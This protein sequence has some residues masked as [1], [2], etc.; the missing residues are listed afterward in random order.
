[1][2]NSESSGCN[3]NV[4]ALERRDLLIR[5]TWRLAYCSLGA[6]F[7]FGGF[8]GYQ[9]WRKQHLSRQTEQFVA[10]GDY[11]SAVLVARRLL[12][13]D[14]DNLPASRAMAEMAENAGQSDAIKWRERLAHLQPTPANHIALAKTALRFGQPVLAERVLEAVPE[15]SRASVAYH[16]VA[17]ALALAQKD[18]A[19]AETHFASALKI[20][21]QNEQV[22]LNLAIVRLASADS[23][24]ASRARESL[25]ALSHQP[26]VRLEALRALAALALA[27]E[28]HDAAEKWT[29]E[30]QA[31][32][33]TNFSDALLHLQ[34]A[35]G[36]EEAN[37]TLQ[38]VKTKAARA[39]A[40]AAELITWLNRHRQAND[41][42]TWATSLPQEILTAQP[43]P[44]AVAESYSFLQDWPALQSWVEGKNWGAFEA[45]RLAVESHAL[46]RLSPPDRPSLQTETVWRA[47]LKTAQ[48]HPEQLIAIAQLAEGWGYISDAQEAWW[49]VA[50]SND[51]PKL[52]LSA[53]QRLYKSQQDTHGLLRVAKRALELNPGDLVA[54]NN[55]ASLGLLLNGDSTSR[56][57][58]SRL[59]SEHPANRAF[60]ATYAFAL[61]SEGKSSE[62]LKVM[63]SLQ[64]EELRHPAIAAY[65]VVLLVESGNLERARAYLGNAQRA[66]LLPEEERLLNSAAR[67]LVA[68]EGHD[69][70][71]VVAKSKI[72]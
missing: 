25:E 5:W 44:L 57:L 42:I 14:P 4:R 3:G 2:Q 66:V 17:G 53:L 21:P 20:E 32:P 19:G 45:M 36:T 40:T 34:S 50:S 60:A 13:F 55:C 47:A 67:K 54:A 24:A 18:S 33:G 27:Q 30:L 46:H 52:G 39:A 62:G 41:A 59:H 71:R 56:R 49:M 22:A 72:L 16:Q 64:E 11:Q 6:I 58:A 1:M 9:H 38:E 26:K 63:E 68:N 7:L 15:N 10:R 61:H 37:I 23:I 12:E 28:N 69:P 29:R 48:A 35:Q 31:E 51:N 43:V 70:A 8:R 65:Y